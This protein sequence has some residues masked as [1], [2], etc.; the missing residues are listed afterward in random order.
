MMSEKLK[1][2]QVHESEEGGDEGWLVSYADMVT[3][4]FGFFVI[5]YSMANLD[6][7][8][9]QQ[10]GE[11]L[12]TAFKA[13]EQDLQ[14]NPKK[15]VNASQEARR[16]RAMQMIAGM[17]NPSA[18]VDQVVQRIEAA[19]QDV[20]QAKQLRTQL[21]VAANQMG[22]EIFSSKPDPQTV[23]L[24]LPENILFPP[25]SDAL[26]SSAQ[27]KLLQLAKTISSVQKVER[28]EVV[29]H[30][31]SSPPGSKSMFRNNFALSSARAGSVA[32]VLIQGGVKKD[33]LRVRGMAD[34][35]PIVKES[36]VG[37]ELASSLAV[38]KKQRN[39]LPNSKNRRVHLIIRKV[40]DE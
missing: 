9:F 3:L 14:K 15:A 10:I 18:S 27:S 32:A 30:T 4:L 36:G 34:L 19:S 33:L 7:K 5:L 38:N 22:E 25:G 39:N 11:G 8:K 24:V 6:E 21:Q 40:A 29:G 28:I 12:A 13:P 1:P 37:K 16:A 26:S 31:D 35:E 17:L 23:E 20:A 2:W